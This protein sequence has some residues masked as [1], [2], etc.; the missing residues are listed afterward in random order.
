MRGIIWA[1]ALRLDGTVRS[2]HHHQGD[3]SPVQGMVGAETVLDFLQIPK[4]EPACM[5]VGASDEGTKMAVNL[6]PKQLRTVAV[7]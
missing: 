6:Q 3:G 2:Y 1:G 7:N 5:Y 4:M